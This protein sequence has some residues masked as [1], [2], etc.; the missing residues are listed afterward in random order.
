MTPTLVTSRTTLPHKG[1]NF[2]WG[3]PEE[4]YHSQLEL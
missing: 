2:P 3:G 1:I 4:N